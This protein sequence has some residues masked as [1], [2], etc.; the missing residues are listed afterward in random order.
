RL[1]PYVTADRAVDGAVLVL[2]DIDDLKRTER[3][4]TEAHEHAAAIIRTVPNPLV[5]LTSDL[6]VQSTNDAF[7][8]TF[9][10]SPK[11]VKDCSIFK[12]DSGAWNTPRLRHLLKEVIPRDS[13]FNEFELTHDFERIG[14][15][16]LLLNARVLNEPG[17]K[18]KEILLGI[19]D[20]TKV[21]AFQTD[22]RRSE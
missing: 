4:I 11:D 14:R 21:L 2:V 20:V 19:Q 22:L 7:N 5:T 6:R 17:S 13:S 9:K 12:I 15:R 1:R 8:R 16:S 10:I 3:L 18:T